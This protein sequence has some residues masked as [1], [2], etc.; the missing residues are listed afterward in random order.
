MQSRHTFT[1]LA[2]RFSLLKAIYVA[3]QVIADVLVLRLAFVLAYRL[4][5]V[6]DPRAELA[7]DPLSDYDA[8]SAMY[9]GVMI[10]VFAARRMYIPSRGVSWV[11]MLYRVVSAVGIGWVLSLA[12]TLVVYRQLDPPRLMLIYWGLLS[13][14][15][16]WLARV[17]LDFV[18]R[19]AR[20]R[21]RDVERAL[22]V[23]DG[24]QAQMLAQRI[25]Q[26]PDLGYQV[27]GFIGGEVGQDGHFRPPQVAPILGGLADVANVVS[28]HRVGEV[29]IAW[30]GISHPQLV[31]IVTSCQR[32][33][34]NIKIF[35]DIFELIAREVES[36]ELS[37]LPLMRVRDVA[38]RG[39]SRVVKRAMDVLVAWV[40]LV[41]L[42]PVVLVVALLVKLTSPDGPV[43]FVQERVGLDGEPFQMIKFRSMRPDAEGETGPVW[44][45][46]GDPRRTPLGAFMRRFSIDELPQLVNVLSGEMSLVG[47]RPERPE[48][49]AEFA[50]LVPRYQ[51]RHREKAGMTGWAAVNG[52]RGNTSVAERTKYDLFYVENWSLAFDLKIMLKTIGVVFR[53]RNAY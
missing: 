25:R 44:A 14:G 4:R 5:L 40:L 33:H 47:P 1:L 39:W 50:T 2:Q 36:S 28:A 23:G 20:R 49:V 42:S 18:L 7:I 51:E 3:A 10:V 29:I 9:I 22:I 24:E 32:Y 30:P 48:F 6:G 17:S 8:L 35:P 27:V 41:L 45:R 34:V 11:D 15:L 38:L 26:S 37:G 52:L 16:V 13:I 19:D 53:D 12:S 46:P 21:G 43:F 31:D